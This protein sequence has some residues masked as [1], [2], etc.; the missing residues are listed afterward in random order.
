[1]NLLFT[2]DEASFSSPYNQRTRFYETR[3]LGAKQS[4]T[5]EGFLICY[6]V[7]IARAGMMIYSK[8]DLPAL[9]STHDGIIYVDRDADEVF[10]QKA[11]SSFEGKP[12]TIDHPIEDVDPSN[13]KQYAVGYTT[14]V[15]RGVG[16]L[17]D[18]LIADLI[19]TDADA[20]REVRN[21]KREV[22][23]GYDADYDQV[24]PGFGKQK[25]IIGNHVAIVDSGRCG[26]RCK[27]GDS[28]MAKV[29]SWLDRARRAFMTRDAEE[30]ENAIK[31]KEDKSDG[32]SAS[33]ASEKPE[34]QAPSASSS[35]N[36]P[37][38][39][40]GA[41]GGASG[42]THHH[43]VVNVG[44]APPGSGA[45]GGA[46]ASGSAAAAPVSPGGAAGGA[47]VGANGDMG[48]D[49]NVDP[50]AVVID[51]IQKLATRVDALEQRIDANAPGQATA[52][53][54]YG[55]G[56]ADDDEGLTQDARTKLADIMGGKQVKDEGETPRVDMANGQ[57]PRPNDGSTTRDRRTVDA[58]R[59]EWLDI[60]SRAEILVPGIRFPTFDAAADPKTMKDRSCAFR[61]RVL[62]SALEIDK[63]RDAISDF[64]DGKTPIKSMT[65]DAVNVLFLGASS[66]IRDNNNRSQESVRTA[67]ANGGIRS[68]ADIN[69]RNREIWKR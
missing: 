54:G 48:A 67:V 51:A 16:T 23:C 65:C 39:D 55:E 52:G 43:I 47:E 34:K 60:V 41:G 4:L 29:G 20:I 46:D 30:F 5:P 8:Y 2:R 33:A 35:P 63:S 38:D 32:A 66:K 40:A 28:K 44:A 24:S 18:S 10:S 64:Y 25:S 69:K 21:G 42:G 12:V 36:P 13:W 50:W 53:D 3:Q 61:R 15:R 56:N 1:M 14:N 59:E 9:K 11:I 27:I 57:D 6:D 68:I 17:E 45:A 7:P 37:P 58:M 49:S 19:I 22:S 62:S 31:E 26:P